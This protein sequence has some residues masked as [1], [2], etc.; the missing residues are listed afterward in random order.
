MLFNS[1]DFAVFLPIVFLLYWLV[2]PNNLKKQNFLI[3]IMSYVFYGWWD[4]RFLA[5]IIIS[6]L[7]DYF[8]GLK[9]EE[10]VEPKTRKLLLWLSVTVNLGILGFFKYF[11]FFIENFTAAFTFFGA[12]IQPNTLNLILPVGIS[13]Y[14]FQSMTYT[15]DV[16]WRKIKPTRDVIAFFAYLSFFPQ[17]VAGP[18][19]RAINFLPQF[20]KKREFDYSAA[21]DGM[22]QIL[23]GLF[24]KIVI[25]DNC[26]VFVDSIFSNYTEH[27]GST[28]LLGS[29]L[30]AFQIYGDF[31]G[32]SDIAIGSARLFG[33]NLLQNFRYPYFSTS[34]TEMWRR[35]HISLSNWLREYL[36]TP[37]A[38]STRNWGTFGIIFSSVITFLLCG[39]WHGANWVYVVFGL[40]H[41]LALGYE[42]LTKKLRKKWNKRIPVKIYYF[43]SVFLT[44]VFW[45]ISLI[46]FH[47][48]S[49]GDAF[50]YLN[51]IFSNTLFSMP[52]ADT[53]VN[54]LTITV[55]IPIFI[56][57]EW[58]QKDKIHVLQLDYKKLPRYIRWIIYVLVV[59]SIG[60]LGNTGDVP[61]IYFQF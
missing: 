17:L 46:F 35:W 49:L 61:F 48:S 50:A 33:F 36:Y 41:G 44:F 39:L 38:L 5:L 23:W 52:N 1:I 28:L 3:V 58:L 13:F 59:F 56:M 18:I 2:F 54:P 47:S 6:T 32:Y 19:E 16:Y 42:L 53:G 45:N 10:D 4:W 43:G 57:A 29:V 30:F 31:S 20:T 7:I 9:L 55:L 21:V 27:S 40:L 37:I 12:N 8:I 11:N 34:I 26:A 14:T 25:A 60:M 24:K 15:I 22:R 51:G